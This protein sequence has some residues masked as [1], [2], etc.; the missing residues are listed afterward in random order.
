MMHL[1]KILFFLFLLNAFILILSCSNEKGFF[2]PTYWNKGFQGITFTDELGEIIR[3]DPDDWKY[4]TDTEGFPKYAA[5]YPA[6][7]NPV[8]LGK[9]IYFQFQLPKRANVKLVIV[10]DNYNTLRVLCD[11]P[12]PAGFYSVMWDLKDDREW[13]M[14]KGVYRCLFFVN[15]NQISYGDI[16]IK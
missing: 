14:L 10:N 15:E 5:I 2:D 12:H 4:R 7:P 11:G 6:Y 3:E 8:S 16:W 1:N 13:L 9:G